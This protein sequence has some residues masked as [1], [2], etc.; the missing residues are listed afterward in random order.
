M[1]AEEL[2]NRDLIRS[3]LVFK[4]IAKFHTKKTF[5]NFGFYLIIKFC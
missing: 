4:L 3:P 2:K 1:I 5:G